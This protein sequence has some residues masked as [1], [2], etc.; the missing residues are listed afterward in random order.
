L[1]CRHLISLFFTVALSSTVQAASSSDRWFDVEL[2][3]FKRNVDIQNFSEQLDQNNVY[4]KK[5]ARLD[6]FKAP[7]ATDCF[8]ETK[9]CLHQQ[10]PVEITANEVVKGN[11]RLRLLDNSHLQLIE[12]RQTLEDHTLFTPLMHVAWRM[13][14]QNQKQALP[15]H[16]FAGQNY[17]LDIFKSE[18]EE[19]KKR[20]TTLITQKTTQD[21]VNEQN[22]NTQQESDKLDVLASLQKQKTMQ[23]LYEIDGNLLIYVER[24]LFVDGQLI[25][26]TE[27]KKEKSA[28][29][30]AVLANT[31]SENDTP[32]AAVEVIAQESIFNQ[33]ETAVTETLFD[34]KRRLRSEEIH[35][36]DH[37]LFGIIIQIRKIP[38]KELAI[39]NAESEARAKAEV[40]LSTISITQ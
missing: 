29:P 18:I 12:Q 39:L 1:N 11:H 28:M 40:E 24:Y 10:I 32:Q 8:D 20:E 38:A 26:R 36:L 2:L 6:V 19:Q 13:P 37:P 14:V 22:N 34:Q 35:Y 3:V 33:Y 25:V 15:I 21:N 17:A 31:I 7:P 5:R 23:D 9:P 16:L 4:L 27:T 30:Q